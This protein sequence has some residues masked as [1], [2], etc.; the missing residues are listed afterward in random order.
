MA[1]C[2]VAGDP[3][4]WPSVGDPMTLLATPAPF[5]TLACHSRHGVVPVQWPAELNAQGWASGVVRSRE[6]LPALRR[7]QVAKLVFD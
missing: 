1:M 4:F 5:G 6:V 3:A 2:V 7:G